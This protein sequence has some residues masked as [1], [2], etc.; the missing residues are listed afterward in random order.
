[1]Q[2]GRLRL[3]LSL[4]DDNHIVAATD[5]HGCGIVWR[6][7]SSPASIDACH[8][9]A[10][11]VCACLRCPAT[12]PH[13]HAG[14]LPDQLE[15]SRDCRTI[16]VSNEGEPRTYS[17]ASLAN[18]PEGSVSVINLHFC[19]SPGD[20]VA[21][22]AAKPEESADKYASAEKEEAVEPERHAKHS[23]RSVVE[24][25]TQQRM[26]DTSEREPAC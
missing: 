5:M 21:Y 18:D 8:L 22:A 3:L 25:D 9:H 1:M 15:F 13:L 12:P 23:H 19:E 20:Y 7:A 17:P 4:Y 11:L 6:K 16:L 10:Q 14:A 24:R 2:L 26:C